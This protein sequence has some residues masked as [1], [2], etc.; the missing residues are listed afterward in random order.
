MGLLSGILR[1]VMGVGAL[2]L[3]G[4]AIYFT[5]K[6]I[7]KKTVKDK[8]HKEFENNPAFKEAFA[9]K[10][11][12]KAEKSISLDVLNSWN[13]VIIE[14]IE[15]KGDEVADDINVGTVIELNY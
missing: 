9:A 6:K 4:A 1:I 12:R 11:K 15:I 7:N 5:V 3:A 10:V 14:D 2:G 13:S 8:L